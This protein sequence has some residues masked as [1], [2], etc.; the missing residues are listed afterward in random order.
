MRRA[1]GKSTIAFLRPV[2]FAAVASF[3][4]SADVRV[5][6]QRLPA[7]FFCAGLDRYE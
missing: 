3:C 7:L 4:H 6:F 5:Q 1:I 2:D